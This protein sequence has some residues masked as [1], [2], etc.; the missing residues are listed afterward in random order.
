MDDR[1]EIRIL[2]VEPGKRAITGTLPT[3][4]HP[5]PGQPMT[6]D[7][8]ATWTVRKPW[9]QRIAQRIRRR[10]NRVAREGDE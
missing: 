3:T 9:W 7:M 8:H 2:R 1:D 10:M 5:L 4:T 6:L